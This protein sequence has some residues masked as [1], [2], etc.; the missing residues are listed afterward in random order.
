M[1][2]R[3]SSR[4]TVKL[5]IVICGLYMLNEQDLSVNW[6]LKRDLLLLAR[7]EEFTSFVIYALELS[8]Q[9]EQKD[10]WD[11]LQHT[12]G[13]GKLCAMQAYDFSA[14]EDQACW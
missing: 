11:M 4:E 6:Q 14:P 10:L 13:W 7:C 2:V 1:D 3:A 8:H 5:A 12:S 9:L